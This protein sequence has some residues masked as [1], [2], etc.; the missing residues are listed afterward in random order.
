MASH[1]IHSHLGTGFSFGIYHFC[2]DCRVVAHKDIKTSI[3]EYFARLF[4]YRER[5]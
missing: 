3:T 2:V 5:E 1:V 4:G